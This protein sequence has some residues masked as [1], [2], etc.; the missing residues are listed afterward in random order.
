MKKLIVAGALLALGLAAYTQAQPG[1][2]RMGAGRGMGGGGAFM[3]ESDWALI[4][5][6]LKVEKDAFTQLRAVYQQAWDQR[7]EVMEQMQKGGMDRMMLMEEMAMIQE[8]L[9]IGYRKVLTEEEQQQ[10]ARLRAQ[11]RGAW[12]RR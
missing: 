11:R 2:G 1:G 12:Q 10:L 9:E 8:D 7:R 6:E 5:F 3:L 4:C